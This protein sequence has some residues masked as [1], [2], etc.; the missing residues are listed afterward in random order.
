M[1]TEANKFNPD[2]YRKKRIIQVTWLA[3][4]ATLLA[5]FFPMMSKNWINLTILIIF[6]ISLSVSR[7]WVKK[8]KLDHGSNL[9]TLS[10]TVI[11]L[12]LCVMN[13]GIR[14]EVLLV[15]PALISFA[16]LTGT[17]RFLWSIYALIACSV[18]SM[19]LVNELAIYHHSVAGTG[20]ES[21]ILIII[22]LSVVTYSIKLLGSDLTSANKKLLE[23]QEELEQKVENR[24]QELQQTINSLTEA[25]TNLV[26]AEKMASLGRLVAGVAHE[27]N[28]PLGIA[29]TASSLI[30]ESTSELKST[31][32]NNTVTKSGL[33]TYVND[34]EQSIDMVQGNLKRAASLISDFKQAAVIQSDERAKTFNLYEILQTIVA[35]NKTLH[36][37]V[38]ANVYGD[39]AIYI[40]QD[41]DAITRIFTNLYSNS[42]IHGFSDI[43][44]GHIDIEI[45]QVGELVSIKYSD[46]GK[47]IK[48]ENIE[49][50]F[51]PFFTT[52]RGK[53][54]TG[55]GMHIVYNLVT[56]SLKGQI[57][58]N[59]DYCV[60]ACFE[61]SFNLA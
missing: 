44:K 28:T 27:I 8:N 35:H 24:T 55:L 40:T 34:I 51:E 22:I 6:F 32:T 7:Y 60:G 39:K 37:Q 2:E 31:L 4:S 38:T 50:I 12:V 41:P 14:D 29:I 16:V 52:K 56:Q 36:T 5:S 13:Q 48:K 3:Q 11:I 1:E 21:A 18:M 19:G 58:Y 30:H 53:G 59:P 54:G 47:G 26:E 43:E 23:Y 25:K 9:V 33:T 10:V 17:D 20:L 45:S 61:I 49:H 46:N 15:F 42:C 57:H